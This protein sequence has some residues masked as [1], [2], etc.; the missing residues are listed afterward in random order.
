MLANK[1]QVKVD[2][3]LASLAILGRVEGLRTTLE[4]KNAFLLEDMNTLV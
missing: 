1:N 3:S 2:Y 4:Y